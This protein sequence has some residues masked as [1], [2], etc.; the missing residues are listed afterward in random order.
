MKKYYPAVFHKEEN[1]YWVEFPDLKGCFSQGKD[2][3]EACTMAE[4]ALGEWINAQEDIGNVIP[5]P[6][7]MEVISNQYRDE[8]VSAIAYDDYAWKEAHS[9][10]AVRK[11]VSIPEWMDKLATKNGLSLSKILQKALKNELHL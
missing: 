2:F 8:C 3:P 4:D 5:E 11:A 9:T 6:S 10:R 1:S 7:S